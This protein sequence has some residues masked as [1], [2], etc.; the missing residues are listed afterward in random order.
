MNPSTICLDA[1]DSFSGAYWVDSDMDFSYLAAMNTFV[2]AY[3]LGN[4]DFSRGA[5]PA[6]PLSCSVLF[7]HCVIYYA[8]ATRITRRVHPILYHTY[9]SWLAP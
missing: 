6:A 3:V 9:F 1:G 7:F 5:F 8:I 2:D 4:H